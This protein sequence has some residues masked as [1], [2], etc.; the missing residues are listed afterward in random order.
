MTYRALSHGC[1]PQLRDE[2]INTLTKGL[3]VDSTLSLR[4]TTQQLQAATI[5]TL[6]NHRA[7]P[8]CCENKKLARELTN[9]RPEKASHF[10]SSILLLVVVSVR[11]F[12]RRSTRWSMP[13][14]GNRTGEQR[15]KELTKRPDAATDEEAGNTT[16]NT[17]KHTKSKKAK[18]E[19]GGGLEN[20]E[21]Q[22]T[23]GREKGTPHTSNN[24]PTG[25]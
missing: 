21:E 24:Q 18:E 9:Q 16:T 4:A 11:Q 23:S 22:R 15:Y 25:T 1:S 5:D 12:P 2:P 13:D 10:L 6:K 7:R 14:L 17:I 20:N 19:E 3:I 8:Q